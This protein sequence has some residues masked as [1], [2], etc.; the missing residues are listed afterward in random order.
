MSDP[1]DYQM[2]PLV[3]VT[4]Y[5]RFLRLS[6]DGDDV[7]EGIQSMEGDSE[8]KD[9]GVKPEL[10]DNPDGVIFLHLAINLYTHE[11]FEVL[12]LAHG[13]RDTFWCIESQYQLR[14][15]DDGSCVSFPEQQ[16]WD[17]RSPLEFLVALS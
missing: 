2:E 3:G 12:R 13:P 1:E 9:K 10:Q 5:R 4:T 7:D 6:P 17:D 8:N 14:F 16:T 11:P 15:R